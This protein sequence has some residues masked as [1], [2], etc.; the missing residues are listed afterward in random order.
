M[1]PWEYESRIQ[2]VEPTRMQIFKKMS[3]DALN[4]VLI[5]GEESTQKIIKNRTRFIDLGAFCVE[6]W[7][8]QVLYRISAPMSYIWLV[9]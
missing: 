6:L 9:Y 2:H 5:A 3:Q 7:P 8:K 4:H 1:E